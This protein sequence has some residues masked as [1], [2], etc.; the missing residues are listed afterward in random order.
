MNPEALLALISDLY[1]QV[2]QQRQ[3]IAQLEQEKLA[4]LKDR[5]SPGPAPEREA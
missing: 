1:M 4:L 3:Q 2:A 5:D